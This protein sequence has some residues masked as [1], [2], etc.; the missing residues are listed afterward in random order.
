MVV[1]GEWWIETSF[2]ES[3]RPHESFLVGMKRPVPPRVCEQNHRC[4]QIWFGT[5]INTCYMK[6]LYS[7]SGKTYGNISTNWAT[8]KEFTDL[9]LMEFV[10]LT[11]KTAVTTI[12]WTQSDQRA[13]KRKSGNLIKKLT[14]LLYQFSL[15]LCSSVCTLQTVPLAL[16][17]GD[18]KSISHYVM[19]L[20]NHALYLH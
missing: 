6:H 19:Q 4:R 5:H 2:S 12:H 13:E 7:Y 18:Y 10:C 3:T 8:R 20:Q 17:I 14:F 16:L 1:S 9:M 11:S 15:S